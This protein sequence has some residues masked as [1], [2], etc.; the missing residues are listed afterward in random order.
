MAS[1]VILQPTFS[2]LTGSEDVKT[3]D[4]IFFTMKRAICA[5]DSEECLLKQINWRPSATLNRY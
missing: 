3:K 5:S 4:T 2:K 1:D